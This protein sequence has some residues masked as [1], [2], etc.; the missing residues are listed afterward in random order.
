MCVVQYGG[1]GPYPSVQGE[2][3]RGLGQTYTT[4]R[5]YFWA[6]LAQQSGKFF[7]AKHNVCYRLSRVSLVCGEGSD[8]GDPWQGMPPERYRSFGHVMTTCRQQEV[9]MLR[10]RLGLAIAAVC[11]TPWLGLAQQQP[12]QAPHMTFFVTSTGPGKGADLGGLGGADQ[13]CQTL[14]NTVGAGGKTWRAYLS[15]QAEGNTP[16]VNARDRI[17][18]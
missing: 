5:A 16:A 14:A 17:G 11:L 2:N 18:T 10:V 9:T 12:P 3:T 1:I 7:L 6:N 8:H 15:A 13:Q 4:A